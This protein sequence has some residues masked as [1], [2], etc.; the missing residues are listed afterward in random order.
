M[1][2][3]YDRELYVEKW[4]YCPDCERMIKVTGQPPHECTAKT[5]ETDPRRKAPPRPESKP[6]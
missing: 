5:N 2:L 1:K 3:D 6:I 4:V